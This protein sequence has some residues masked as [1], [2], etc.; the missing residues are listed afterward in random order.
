VPQAEAMVVSD[1][2]KVAFIGSAADAIEH[3]GPAAMKVDLGGRRMLPGLVESHIH[4]LFGTGA[5]SGLL[6]SE[7]DSPC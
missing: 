1:E 5:T 6:F 2:G 3:A 7:S 4:V